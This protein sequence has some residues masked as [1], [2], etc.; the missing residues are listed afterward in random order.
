MKK[1]INIFVGAATVS[2]LFLAVGILV[3]Q[4]NKAVPGFDAE[5]TNNVT[6][7]LGAKTENVKSD[8]FEAKVLDIKEID[9]K[10][11]EYQI[12]VV[13]TNPLYSV[14]QFS[15]EIN[16]FAR[17]STNKIYQVS[18]SKEQPLDSRPINPKESI[19][20]QVSVIM[21]KGLSPILNYQPSNSLETIEV[22]L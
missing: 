6:A 8:L 7:S 18:P 10:T 16:L 1:F 14:L 15:S 21:P 3:N 12:Q 22:V 19:S 9:S 11:T 20:G 13:I 5:E 4:K 2:V 17:D